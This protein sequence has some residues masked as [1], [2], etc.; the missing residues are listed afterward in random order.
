MQNELIQKATE[1]FPSIDHWKSFQE[2][3]AQN[4]NIR[5]HW[6]IEPTR[7]IRQHFS[8]TLSEAWGFQSWGASHRDTRWYLR[9]FGP[10]SASLWFGFYYCF[11]LHVDDLDKFS[12]QQMAN[13]LSMD[14]AYVPLLRAFGRIDK[15]LPEKS[16]LEE[17][18][19]F[20]FGDSRDFN[21][22]DVD[23]AWY[24]ANHT[25][26]FVDQAI[27]KIEKF[28]TSDEVTKLLHRLNQS[29]VKQKPAMG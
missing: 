1:L 29:G 19:N 27:A 12:V 5:E 7:K 22:T 23:L 16:L 17:T 20:H 11:Y 25:T 9:E 14:S 26:A 28:T 3:C 24:A 6:F 21:F 2:L 10:R 13:S 18:R 15:Q 8:A 4:N